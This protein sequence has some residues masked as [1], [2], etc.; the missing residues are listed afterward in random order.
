MT[1]VGR[2]ICTWVALGIAILGTTTAHA[3]TTQPARGWQETVEQ[4]A[5]AVRGN[6]LKALQKCLDHGPSICTF[7]SETLQPPERLMGTTTGAKVLGMHAYLK[8]PS[9]LATDLADD[10]KA[11][12]VPEPLRRDFVISEEGLEKDANET[13]ARWVTQ[14]LKPQGDQPIAV[15][16]LWR[17]ERADSF[18]NAAAKRPVFLLIRGEVVDEQYIIRQIAYGDPLER[19]R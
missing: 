5:T 3:Q 7:N 2:Y 14:A 16:V 6:N 19:S 12:D 10:F 17:Q 9:T 18:Q 11:S 8:T 15:L 4:F 1:T 13:A